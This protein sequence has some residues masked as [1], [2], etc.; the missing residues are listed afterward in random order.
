M[1]ELCDNATSAYNAKRPYCFVFA[2]STSIN[3]LETES[4]SSLFLYWNNFSAILTVASPLTTK[5]RLLEFH[6]CY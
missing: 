2:P 6:S 4:M 3:G 1:I 5:G